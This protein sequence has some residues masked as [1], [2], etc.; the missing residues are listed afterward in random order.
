MPA[1]PSSRIASKARCSGVH[2]DALAQ[3]VEHLQHLDVEHE[4]LVRRRQPAL[5]PPAACSTRSE[6][7]WYVAHS[8][9]A[10]SNAD[11]AST[12]LPEQRPP[13]PRYGSR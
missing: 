7:E 1:G 6:P 5:Q 4:L 9:I 10:V 3:P 2:H 8:A 13:P 11:C 12:A